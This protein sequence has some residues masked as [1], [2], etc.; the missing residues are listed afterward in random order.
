MLLLSIFICSRFEN[1]FLPPSVCILQV[2][3]VLRPGPCL[4]RTNRAG[5]TTGTTSSPSYL[6]LLVSGIHALGWS[7]AIYLSLGSTQCRD[8]CLTALFSHKRTVQ[9]TQS[10]QLGKRTFSKLTSYKCVKAMLFVHINLE[11]KEWI[12][13]N[14]VSRIMKT[15][16]SMYIIQSGMAYAIYIGIFIIMLL[17]TCH[18]TWTEQQPQCRC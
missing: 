10:I 12:P 7:S 18:N 8:R 1:V 13:C 2:S 15:Y 17:I 6:C 4:T 16:V 9:G 14:D 5:A 11:R 3:R